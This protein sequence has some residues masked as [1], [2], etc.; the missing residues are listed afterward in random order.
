MDVVLRFYNELTERGE[1]G[2]YV[3]GK[4]KIGSG[5]VTVNERKVS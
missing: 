3:M 5:C 1:R 2:N 4:V